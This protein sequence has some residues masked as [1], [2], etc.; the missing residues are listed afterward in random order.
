MPL[1]LQ[2]A[3]FT[4]CCYKT[5]LRQRQDHCPTT[6]C[7]SWLKISPGTDT[8]KSTHT[9]TKKTYFPQIH[10]HKSLIPVI[11]I[12]AFLDLESYLVSISQGL[13]GGLQSDLPI[14]PWPT[15][16]LTWW[17]GPM[18]AGTLWKVRTLESFSG[19]NEKTSKMQ[20]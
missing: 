3:F 11:L 2:N 9:H 15:L 12:V 16:S 20:Q 18:V 6:L 14:T 13:G 1:T 4:W 19:Q 17:W 8:A 5:K 10:T 7:S